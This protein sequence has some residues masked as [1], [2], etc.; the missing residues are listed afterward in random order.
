M[1]ALLTMLQHG[2]DDVGVHLSVDDIEK[3]ER[4]ISIPNGK[5]GVVREAVRL[6]DILI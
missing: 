5:D 2:L 4:P 3:M 1:H 6:M